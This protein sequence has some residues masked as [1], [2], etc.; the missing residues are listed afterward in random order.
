MFELLLDEQL[1]EDHSKKWEGKVEQYYNRPSLSFYRELAKVMYGPDY[2]WKV[3]TFFLN[4]GCFNEN[5][6]LAYKLYVG[7]E[8]V[9]H[10]ARFF[11][12]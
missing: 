2:E 1:W 9:L 12:L 8:A 10:R 7:Q 4:E 5:Y 3:R 11:E 6:E